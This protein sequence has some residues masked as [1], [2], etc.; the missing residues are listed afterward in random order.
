MKTG[1]LTD[2]Y[3]NPLSGGGGGGP[4]PAIDANHLY[5][6]DCSEAS[7][8]TT[9][10]NTGSGVNGT[11]TL[12]GTAGTDYLLSS[13]RIGRNTKSFRSLILDG[14]GYVASGTSCSIT[15]GSLSLEMFTWFDNDAQGMT[16]GN[17]MWVASAG[18]VDAIYFNNQYNG[19]AP[20]ITLNGVGTFYSTEQDGI[21]ST[22]NTATYYMATYAGATG[23]LTYYVNG[24]AIGSITVTGGAHAFPTVVQ[25][26]FN[27]YPGSNNSVKG[28][29]TQLRY[30]NIARSASYALATASTLLAM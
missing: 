2:P 22:I 26:G 16:D 24:L 17:S 7:G 10:A 30:S 28:W 5:V 19:G 29:Y 8:S 27:G 11:L 23:V 21:R 1:I 12:H 14:A 4:A 18:G 9:L 6:Y 25:I 3:G 15:G 20:V 13:Q